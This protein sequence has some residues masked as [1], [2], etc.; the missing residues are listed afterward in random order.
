MDER[1]DITSPIFKIKPTLKFSETMGVSPHFWENMWFR[2]KYQ[3]YTPR[4]LKEWFELKAGKPISRKTIYRWI[5]RQELYDD[6]HLAVK[7]GAQIVTISYF[8]RHKN[9]VT[10]RQYLDELLDKAIDTQWDRLNNKQL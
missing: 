5:L 9:V 7:R 3:G 4:D 2:Y 8:K 6:A 1:V 10:N